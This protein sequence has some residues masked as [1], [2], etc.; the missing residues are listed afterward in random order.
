MHTNIN[1]DKHV[2]QISCWCLSQDVTLRLPW[3][4]ICMKAH[5]CV[6][7]TMHRL[8]DAYFLRFT[9]P[10][11][12]TSEHNESEWDMHHKYA[13]LQS[14]FFFFSS[15]M[16][17]LLDLQ[18]T[19][20]MALEACFVWGTLHMHRETKHVHVCV[21]VRTSYRDASIL[22]QFPSWMVWCGYSTLPTPEPTSQR[23]FT[24]P[25]RI[26]KARKSTW[27]T[28]K[29]CAGCTEYKLFLK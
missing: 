1:I 6:C 29:T 11:V 9:P 20:V 25:L 23:K 8:S 4:Y 26:S 17:L 22:C 7:A 5:L 2:L 16:W 24:F 28:Q 15:R 12:C 13:S 18:P 14:C 19:L 3:P 27:D 21:C 10:H